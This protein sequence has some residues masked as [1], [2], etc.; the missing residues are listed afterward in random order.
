MSATIQANGWQF[1][2]SG[3]VALIESTLGA[4]LDAFGTDPTP[5]IGQAPGFSGLPLAAIRLDRGALVSARNDWLEALRPVVTH[6][7]ADMLFSVFGAYELARV[8]R[9]D[10]F[11]AWGPVF[12]FF[13]DAST[14]SD[15]GDPRV[16]RLSQDD[17]GAV[18]YKRFWH[19]FY[20]DG[21]DGYGL[22]QD[23]ELVALAAVM[24]HAE[25]IEEIGMDVMPEARGRGLG[26]AVVGAAGTAII[27]RG[28]LALATTSPWNVPSARTLRSAGL[29]YSYTQM[30]A[31]D[32]FDGAFPMP[33]QPLG[34]PYPGARMVNYYPA[35]A[36]NQDVEPRPDM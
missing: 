23:G 2:P 19:C 29:R 22:I 30:M 28:N 33:A 12:F 15:P 8:T 6:M 31:F 25:G 20:G 21:H 14:W 13:G 34:R 26:R 27:E 35:W 32:A 16:V 17:L 4:G 11:S 36:M 7:H 10:G 3:A 5:V 9:P 18:D 1:L 24:H